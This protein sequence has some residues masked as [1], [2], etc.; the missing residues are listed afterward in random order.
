ME[1]FFIFLKHDFIDDMDVNR[2]Y[3]SYI[4]IP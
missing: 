2:L 4:I 1:G 3:Q